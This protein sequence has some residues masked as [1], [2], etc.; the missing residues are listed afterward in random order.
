VI[1]ADGIS[2]KFGITTASPVEADFNRLL[3]ERTTGLKIVVSTHAKFG[4]VSN[5]VTCSIN[6][7]DVIVTD[8]INDNLI[9]DELER[10]GIKLVL[11]E[12]EA[13]S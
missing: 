10:T 11:A 1:G 3:L 13:K 4:V 9:I 8:T 12:K 6:E 2:P 7:I 5:F